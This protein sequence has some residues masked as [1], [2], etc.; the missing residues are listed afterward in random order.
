MIGISRDMPKHDKKCTHTHKH[1]LHIPTHKQQRQKN[2]CSE[3]L[4]SFLTVTA[5]TFETLPILKSTNTKKCLFKIKGI[6]VSFATF[7]FFFQSWF[8]G[9]V[10][11]NFGIA[12]Q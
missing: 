5:W 11:S 10:L 7:Y 1:T 12:Q 3:K 6:L 4:S 2:V 9:L 8:S